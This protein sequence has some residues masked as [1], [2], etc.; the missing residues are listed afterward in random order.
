[1]PPLRLGGIEIVIE[2]LHN[3]HDARPLDTGLHKHP[4]Y[5]LSTMS[6]GSMKYV[7]GNTAV[8]ISSGR[9][10]I[11]FI[12]P[13]TVHRR[14]ADG[15]EPSVITGFQI[16]INAVDEKY[17]RFIEVL[18]LEL[19]EMGYKLPA[20][21]HAWNIIAEGLD[22]LYRSEPFFEERAAL[23]INEFFITFFRE[24]FKKPLALLEKSGQSKDSEND[25]HENL[26]LLACR[27]IEEHLARQIRIDE[28][29]Q[30]CGLSKRHLNRIF[31]E[32]KGISLG[33]YIIHRKIDEARKKIMRNDRLIKDVASEL[34]FGNISYFCR[35]FRKVTG[36]TPENYRRVR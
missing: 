16:Q 6:L 35:L 21:F 4:F 11:V 19:R 26:L 17:K 15:S 27:Y 34:G 33:N 36:K 7:I 3:T 8:E 28:I 18:P 9:H 31:T 20:S 2:V 23:F 24:H 14:I 1:M 22:E 32:Y 12:P 30:H 5:E 29:A 13:E 10:D 25:F